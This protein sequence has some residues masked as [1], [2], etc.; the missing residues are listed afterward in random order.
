MKRNH[1]PDIQIRFRAH[2]EAS[3][4]RDEW[5]AKGLEWSKAGKVEQAR[6]ALKKAEYWDLQRRKAEL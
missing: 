2:V 4:K 1:V 6:R 3:I 5:A